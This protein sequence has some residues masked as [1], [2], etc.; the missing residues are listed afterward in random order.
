MLKELLR[1]AFRATFRISRK[2]TFDLL[3]HLLWIFRGFGASRGLPLHN[4][5]GLIFMCV[6][7]SMVQ[8]ITGITKI[9]R[10]RI[11]HVIVVVTWQGRRH[12]NINFLLCWGSAWLRDNRPVKLTKKFMHSARNPGNII[13]FFWLTGQLSQGSSPFQKVC[14]QSL[15]AFFLP[16]KCHPNCSH[17]LLFPG[18]LFSSSQNS[19]G[20]KNDVPKKSKEA[21]L[22]VTVTLKRHARR[23]AHQRFMDKTVMHEMCWR[24]PSK[25]YNTY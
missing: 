19:N 2:P 21:T 16:D 3:F 23:L 24:M 12:I 17:S 9:I 7:W 4:S 25:F 15:C 20:N 10:M 1:P 22:L 14:V 5:G 13:L 18:K 8:K 6:P 11:T